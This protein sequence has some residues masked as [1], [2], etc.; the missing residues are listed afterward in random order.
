MNGKKIN[1]FQNTTILISNTLH[2][3]YVGVET[4]FLSTILFVQ[5]LVIEYQLY[6]N[7]IPIISSIL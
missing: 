1:Y 2:A 3:I 7:L 5:L 6:L 4:L